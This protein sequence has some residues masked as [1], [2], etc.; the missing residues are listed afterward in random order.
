M[1]TWEQILE[2][3]HELEALKKHRAMIYQVEAKEAAAKAFGKPIDYYY[4]YSFDK[5]SVISRKY[6]AKMEK[7]MAECHRLGIP[8]DM[9]YSQFPHFKKQMGLK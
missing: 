3:K 9:P 2:V 1:K 5:W 7:V 4:H 6:Q 8:S